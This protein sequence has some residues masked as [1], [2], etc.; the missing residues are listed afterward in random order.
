MLEIWTQ[1]VE[2]SGDIVGT[3]TENIVSYEDKF[4]LKKLIY[5]K[6]F[7]LDWTFY[8]AEG[9]FFKMSNIVIWLILFMILTIKKIIFKNCKLWGI[10]LSR[11][12]LLKSH[13]F[14]KLM[15]SC[16]K[17]VQYGINLFIWI[18]SVHSKLFCENKSSTLINIINNCK[19]KKYNW[20][21]F[22]KTCSSVRQRCQ[23][24]SCTEIDIE[25]I[26]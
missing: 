15:F 1:S 4:K 2:W 8:I 6:A 11:N 18:I 14:G 22:P 26:N 9:Q 10:F 21:L 23:P 17:N 19:F 13:L 16:I 7:I 20:I 5:L 3:D 25:R 24:V 12:Y